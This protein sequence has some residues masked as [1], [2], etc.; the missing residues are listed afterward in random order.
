MN[1][2]EA[3]TKE[4]NNMLEHFKGQPILQLEMCKAF[5][6]M[7]W[8]LGKIEETHG[9]RTLPAGVWFRHVWDAILIHAPLLFS[10]ADATQMNDAL[11]IM[12]CWFDRLI[13]G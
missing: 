2:M 12:E 1:N 8:M 11:G 5:G 9:K 3:I 4:T 10:A 13:E 7:L 6:M